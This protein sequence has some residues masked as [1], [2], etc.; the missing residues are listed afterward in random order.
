MALLWNKKTRNTLYEVRSAGRSLRLYTNGVFHTQYNPGQPLTGHIWDLLM[1]PAFF[2]P[3]GDIKR[4]LVLGVGGG[5]VMQLLRHFVRP[6]KI[7]GVEL[8]P[9]HVY[10]AKRFFKL[11]GPDLQLVTADAMQWLRDYRGEKFDMIIDDL[12][13]EEN[14]EPVPVASAN[15]EW[16]RLLG[17][18]LSRQGMIVRNFT[19]RDEIK[20]SAGLTNKKISAGFASVFQFNA[21]FNENFAVAYLKQS[22]N[23]RQLRKR[24]V[25]T[26]GLNPALKTSRLRYRIR[27][28]K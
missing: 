22:S 24:L 23:S 9:V 15:A 16:F 26:P 5:A 17:R 19:D 28:L 6:V 13:T 12:F 11:S 10:V 21:T 2:Y 4:V 8:N 1:L 18:R 27:Q 3:C 7:V 14:G 20:K 25:Q